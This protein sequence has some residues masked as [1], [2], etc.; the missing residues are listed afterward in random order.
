MTL[1]PLALPY[2]HGAWGFLLEPIAAGLLV[3]PSRAGAFVALGAVFAFL[4]RH[5]LRF[6]VRDAFVTRKLAPRTRVCFA[7]GAAYGSVALAGFALG[8]ARA[9]IPLA[10][11]APLAA[12]QFAYDVRNRGRERTAELAGAVA[13]GW[14][15]CAIALAAS[16]PVSLAIT[17]WL[18]LSARAVTSVLYVR[19]SLRG[20]SRLVMYSSH[21]LA[22][23]LASALALTGT[24]SIPAIAAMTILAI[25]ALAGTEGLRAKQIG[26]REF[27]YGVVTVLLIAFH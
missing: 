13:A 4:A 25:R 1:R 11:A 6:A 2:E 22:I 3:S 16:A 17:L 20:E 9:L 15:G 21:L 7:L 8:G 14:S 24:A 19:T 12:I 5:P 27:G 26:L 18:L 23:L 10:I